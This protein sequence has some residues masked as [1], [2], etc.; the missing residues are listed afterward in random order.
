[1]TSRRG[2]GSGGGGGV[3]VLCGKLHRRWR[4]KLLE[5]NLLGTCSWIWQKSGGL[6][7]NKIIL[8]GNGGSAADAQ[9]IAAELS[10]RFLKERKG[11]AGIALTTDTSVITAIGNDYGFDMIFERQVEALCIKGDVLIGISTSGNS[12]NVIN[13]LL[14]GKDLDCILVSLTGRDG[15]EIK[16]ISNFNLNIDSNVTARIQE[17]HIL[18]GDILCEYVDEESF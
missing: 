5:F 1:M 11:L 17:M 7:K 9:H 18:L 14:K 8:F 2:G 13:G 10:G 6:S 15:G 3:G 4:W 12:R 16:N